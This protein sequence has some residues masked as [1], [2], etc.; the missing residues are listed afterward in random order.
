M[1]P[2]AALGAPQGRALTHPPQ[3]HSASMLLAEMTPAQIRDEQLRS[4]RERLRLAEVRAATA[5]ERLHEVKQSRV[6]KLRQPPPPP[7]PPRHVLAPSPPPRNNRPSTISPNGSRRSPLNCDPIKSQPPGLE[8]EEGDAL[9]RTPAHILDAQLNAAR[10]SLRAAEEKAA[11]KKDKLEEVRQGR[12]LKPRRLPPPAPPR[13]QFSPPAP[14]P[15]ASHRQ[16]MSP[17]SKPPSFDVRELS[18]DR[19]EEDTPQPEPPKGPFAWVTNV[20]VLFSDLFWR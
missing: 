15:R 20:Q 2:V 18:K 16:Q 5:K 17:E 11:R 10:R 19:Q 7:P 3:Y 6:L 1:P 14:P 8:P 4:A 9:A 12:V 13:R